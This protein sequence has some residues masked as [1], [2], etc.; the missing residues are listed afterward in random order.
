MKMLSSG[1]GLFGNCLLMH[2][3]ISTIEWIGPSAS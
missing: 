1:H 2:A 3:L